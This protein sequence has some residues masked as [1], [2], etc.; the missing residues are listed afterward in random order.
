MDVADALGEFDG[1]PS[2][3]K[4]TDDGLAAGKDERS[5]S[6][7][8]NRNLFEEAEDAAAEHGSYCGGGDDEPALFVGEE[9]SGLLA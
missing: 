4:T 8:A 3:E 1:D 2:P 5:P 7:L 6:D 9:V